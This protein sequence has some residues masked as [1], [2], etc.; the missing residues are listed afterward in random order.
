MKKEKLTSKGIKRLEKSVEEKF[1]ESE[2]KFH[3]VVKSLPMGVHMYELTPSGDLIFGGANPA[4]DKILDVDNSQFIGKTIEEAFPPLAETEVPEKYKKAAS[5][6]IPWTTE[7][8]NYEDDKILG[9]FEVSAFQTS[10]RNMVAVFRDITERKQTEVALQ[11]SE[12]KYR[13][14]FEEFQD[15]YY[16]TDMNGIIE[17]LSP[18]VKHLG[19]YK[20]KD[21]IGTL[22]FDIYK[23]SSDRI[24]FMKELK[25]K[26]TIEDYELTLMGKDGTEIIASA[27]SHIL[28]D[29]HNNPIGIEGVL[30]DVTERKKA[31]DALKKSE[32]E[33]KK[34]RDQL[35][36]V[37]KERT[38]E[39][40]E[41]NEKLK[42]FNNLF[43]GREF[44]IKELRDKVKEL[45]KKI[46]N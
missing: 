43:V 12:E 40:E 22:V 19:G 42:Y 26:G 39:L 6:G 11:R 32:A 20:R 44:R 28:F 10:P 25:K 45:E 5:E 46:K 4:A 1:R 17:D 41:K 14:I 3:N 2:E 33:L 35:E 34:H 37:V 29:E 27:N 7:Q 24:K 8:I 23:N 30:R 18:S 13:K 36:K 21:L 9:A 15:L 31:S 38:I 16:R